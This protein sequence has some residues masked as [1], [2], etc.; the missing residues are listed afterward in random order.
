[1]NRPAQ[2]EILYIRRPIG[3]RSEE[4]G[5]EQNADP[6]DGRAKVLHKLLDTE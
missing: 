5:D 4:R 1:V 6:G 3:S 2:P